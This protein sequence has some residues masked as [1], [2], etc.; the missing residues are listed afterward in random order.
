MSS[1][2]QRNIEASVAALLTGG[3][4]VSEDWQSKA[5][6]EACR[7][8]GMV[9]RGGCFGGGVWLGGGPR[10]EA[11]LLLGCVRAKLV[12]AGLATLAISRQCLALDTT[13]RRQAF[14]VKRPFSVFSQRRSSGGGLSRVFLPSLVCAEV[15][16]SQPPLF[17]EGQ[18]RERML[19]QKML[20]NKL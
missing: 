20:N 14:N 4:K 10:R 15:H 7:H 8:K 6:R 13:R 12:G 1:P 17:R 18:S 11:R 3:W 9:S 5:D 19:Q 2:I 16:L